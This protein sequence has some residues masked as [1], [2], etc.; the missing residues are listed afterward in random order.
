MKKIV[1]TEAT[2][3]NIAKVK[4]LLADTPL[5]LEGLS[6]RL[7]AEQLRTDAAPSGLP[8]RSVRRFGKLAFAVK[9]YEPG[10]NGP[11][12]ILK[13]ADSPET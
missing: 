4:D 7:P 6:K 12:V 5:K 13:V 11:S 9:R 8:A 3:S 10:C 2:N 1:S